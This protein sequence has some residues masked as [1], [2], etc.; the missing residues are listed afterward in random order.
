MKEVE[1]VGADEGQRDLAFWVAKSDVEFHHVRVVVLVDHQADE[2]N[3]S[4]GD[5]KGRQMLMHWLNNSGDDNIVHGRG[6]NGSR[7]IGTQSTCVGTFV[8]L[9]LIQI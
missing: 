4:V 3:P 8:G 6:D 5:L 2:Q 7:T 9:S 1:H